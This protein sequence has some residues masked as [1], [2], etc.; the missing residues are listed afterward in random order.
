MACVG[1]RISVEKVIICYTFHLQSPDLL[2]CK[3]GLDLWSRL[4]TLGNS[5]KFD[6]TR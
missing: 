2:L 3:P 6:C 1:N 5:N 4:L